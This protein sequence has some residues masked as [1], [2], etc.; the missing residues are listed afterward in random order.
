MRLELVS[1]ALK[2]SIRRLVMAKIYERNPD[3]GEIRSRDQHDP[4]ATTA[5]KAITRS[6]IL[7][8]IW[9]ADKTVI[10]GNWI[11]T[12]ALLFNLSFLTYVISCLIECRDVGMCLHC[13]CQIISNH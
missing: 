13:H 3:T 12:V 6:E 5:Q 11:N 2:G 9:A 8:E 4:K 7:D 10:N 1:L